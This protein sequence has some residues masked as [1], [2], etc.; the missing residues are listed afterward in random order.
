MW[1]ETSTN[2]TDGGEDDN[3]TMMK[4]IMM[5]IMM[6]TATMTNAPYS[7]M[8]SNNLFLCLHVNYP[9][10]LVVMYKKQ[11]NF[12]MKMRQR[13]LINMQTKE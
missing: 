1:P 13:G 10:C 11:K 2:N 4:V 7:K 9:L 6:N 12:D 5:I 3:I 8:V